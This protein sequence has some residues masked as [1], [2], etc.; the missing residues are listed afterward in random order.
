MHEM[1]FWFYLECLH[2]SIVHMEGTV[3]KWNNRR[4]VKQANVVD[5]HEYHRY[6]QG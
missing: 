4:L 6:F 5:S 1:V 2:L 3:L